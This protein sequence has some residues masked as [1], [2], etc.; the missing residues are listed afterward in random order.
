MNWRDIGDVP[1][2]T[3][4]AELSRLAS[5]LLAEASEAYE[6][7]RPHTALALAMAFHESKYGTVYARNIVGNRNVMNLRPRGASG[8][9]QFGQW[10]DGVREWRERLTDPGY[11]YAKTV[12]IADLVAV[13]APSYDGNDESAYAQ[14]LTAM[15]ATWPR[16][17]APMETFPK[18]GGSVSFPAIILTAGHRS[19]GDRG[20][21]AEKARTPLLAQAYKRAFE[22]A[23]F[24]V[25][26]WQSID[27]DNRPDQSPGGLDA[28]GRGVQRVMAE[29]PGPSILFDLH[30]EGAAARGVFAIVPDVTGLVTAVPNGAP[31]D[32][33]WAKNAD[34]VTLA[35]LVAKRIAEATGLPLRATTEPGVMSERATGVG[36]QG[37]RLGMFAYTA[38]NRKRSP[39]LVV[40]HGNLSSAAD[41]RI[42]DSPGFYDKCAAASLRAVREIYSTPV[43]PPAPV[44]VE[45]GPYP[46]D[47]D[48][49][50]V[51]GGVTFWAC[52]RAVRASEDARFRQYADVT[53]SETRAPAKPGGEGFR[54]KWA[55]QGTGGEWW[56]VTERGSRVRCSDCDVRVVFAKAL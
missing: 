16:A 48:R 56:W 28:V 33:T 6:A 54:V 36:G 12:T 50:V 19:D 1:Y 40:E 4:Y 47:A 31:A 34:D 14:T 3:W 20:N 24:A 55:V 27:G 51:I 22:G 26:Y 42:I 15:L 13:F 52:D 7:A 2:A 29:I 44:Y 9:Q 8:F 43:V 49:D 10:A 39:R 32:D 41:L 11:A 37:Y 38:G 21:P 53:S 5:P 23:G 46:A 35:R 17:E 30:F 18:I 25:Y 45:P